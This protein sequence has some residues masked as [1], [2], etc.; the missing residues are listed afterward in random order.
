MPFPEAPEISWISGTPRL[1]GALLP[2]PGTAAGRNDLYPTEKAHVADHGGRPA[3][4]RPQDST[5]APS[6]R[7]QQ[8]RGAHVL[9]QGRT[10]A[11]D[12]QG[13]NQ[14]Q[15]GTGLLPQNPA[16]AP[17]RVPGRRQL[18]QDQPLWL[19]WLSTP[20][21]RAG[22]ADRAGHPD[23]RPTTAH[24]LVYTPPGRDQANPETLSLGSGDLLASP[25]AR[26]DSLSGLPSTWLRGKGLGSQD[27]AGSWPG[28]VNT[29]LNARP[30]SCLGAEVALAGGRPHGLSP[31][32]ESRS[33]RARPRG[34]R[35]GT[36]HATPGAECRDRHVPT[37]DPAPPSSQQVPALSSHAVDGGPGRNE[38]GPGKTQTAQDWV[39]ETDVGLPLTRHLPLPAVGP[40]AHPLV[41]ERPAPSGQLRWQPSPPGAKNITGAFA[42]TPAPGVPQEGKAPQSS[43]LV[44][45]TAPV[46]NSLHAPSPG[47]TG[48]GLDAV[49]TAGKRPEAP[50]A[51]QQAPETREQSRR[52][53]P[54]LP[55]PTAP[56][57]QWRKFSASEGLRGRWGPGASGVTPVSGALRGPLSGTFTEP[58]PRRAARSTVPAL[59]NPEP[60]P[61]SPGRPRTLPTAVPDGPQQRPTSE[62]RELL[63]GWSLTKTPGKTPWLAGVRPNDTGRGSNGLCGGKR[64]AQNLTGTRQGRAGVLRPT[65]RLPG[66]VAKEDTPD[67]RS[68]PSEHRD[69]HSPCANPAT[70][71]S[72]CP[73]SPSR[74]DEGL[75]RPTSP[76]PP[77]RLTRA[78]VGPGPEPGRRSLRLPHVARKM[79]APP[80][81][82]WLRLE[83]G[84]R[85]LPAPLGHPG[86][87]DGGP[88]CRGH[89]NP[90]PTGASWPP[91]PCAHPARVD[92]TVPLQLPEEGLQ[93]RR[94]LAAS[95]PPCGALG[96]LACCAFPARPPRAPI[97]WSLFPLRTPQVDV[98]GDCGPEQKALSGQ[99]APLGPPPGKCR[100]LGPR[101]QGLNLKD[102]DTQP[103]CSRAPP[104]ARRRRRVKCSA[105][106]SPPPPSG[107]RARPAIQARRPQTASGGS[108]FGQCHPGGPRPPGPSP[109]L[110]QTQQAG[111]QLRCAQCQPP[112]HT[113]SSH[114]RTAAV[115]AVASFGARHMA[116]T[117]PRQAPD[118]QEGHSEQAGLASTLG[119][120]AEVP[121]HTLFPPRPPAAQTPRPP[122]R[123]GLAAHA[124]LPGPDPAPRSPG[125]GQGGWRHR[126]TH[127]RLPS[128]SLP[129][130]HAPSSGLPRRAQGSADS[131]RS[132]PPPRPRRGDHR[133]CPSRS[134]PSPERG[135]GRSRRGPRVRSRRKGGAGAPE[136]EATRRRGDRAEPAPPPGP[137]HPA[138]SR[139]SFKPLGFSRKPGPGSEAPT[140]DAARNPETARPACSLPATNSCLL[141]SPSPRCRSS[142][143][144]GTP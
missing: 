138:L 65:P 57:L 134:A 70:D 142:G 90:S 114:P 47:N 86:D 52:L 42:R 116:P 89:I 6:D 8:E 101:G 39:L 123:S 102:R 126:P 16:R 95:S 32:P 109:S 108:C 92:C 128:A 140:S 107:R 131:A 118:G 94:R 54:L 28:S 4:P 53:S 50:E 12:A 81:G 71:R 13:G 9:L 43:G 143:T 66:R 45:G 124:L 83:A 17:S 34:G 31:E 64:Q 78:R 14:T 79:P 80:A 7:P 85:P 82:L 106:S 125:R 35:T 15:K 132:R 56:R 72:G 137:P 19:C 135:K 10:R 96:P 63:D 144:S 37:T 133:V 40:Q 55:W 67:T 27:G 33:S 51:R 23:R 18:L 25:W 2:A 105:G 26:D 103:P 49:P 3:G 112:R 1:E 46:L 61:T 59:D 121:R 117:E 111:Q 88:T 129:P 84:H 122:R 110:R 97:S 130:P 141:M 36:P 120:R 74:G 87:R 139:R 73:G 113:T 76:F 69:L 20:T 119:G 41:Q 30:V 24:S 58:R 60:P 44:L 62:Q 11:H 77:P 98:P 22:C 21:L 48:T 104:T 68:R 91:R 29:W 93:V 136:E 127:P 5:A 75:S 115:F 100:G 99:H 38:D